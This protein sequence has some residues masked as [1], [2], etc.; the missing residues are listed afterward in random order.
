MALSARGFRELPCSCHITRADA[1]PAKVVDVLDHVTIT[2]A[3]L[4]RGL[5]FYDAAFAALGVARVSELVDEEEDD[6]LVEAVGYGLADEPA[7]VWVVRGGTPTRGL[8]VRLVAPDRAAVQA[9]HDAAVAAGGAGFAAPRR[10]PIYRRGEFTA[11][12]RDPAGN[13]LEVVAPE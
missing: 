9:F 12:V 10:W 3:D 6:S 5:A 11:M 13:L 1:R 8:H 2:V 7:R 4:D